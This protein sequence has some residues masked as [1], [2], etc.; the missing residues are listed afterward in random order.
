MAADSEINQIID[1]RFYGGVT[2]MVAISIIRKTSWLVLPFQNA[3]SD[4][5]LMYDTKRPSHQQ[6]RS[7]NVVK[8]YD[9]ARTNQFIFSTNLFWG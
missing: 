2:N 5:L 7:T 4:G 8:T 9:V 1:E 6:G 3:E